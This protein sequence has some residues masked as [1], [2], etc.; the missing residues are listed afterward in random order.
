MSKQTSRQADE[1]TSR[2]EPQNFCLSFCPFVAFVAFVAFVPINVV[3]GVIPFPPSV[4]SVSSVPSASSV[5]L[6]PFQ[7]FSPKICILFSFC[8]TLLDNYAFE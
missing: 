1:Q 7:F 8:V 6:V 4:F 5:P 3:V 2:R